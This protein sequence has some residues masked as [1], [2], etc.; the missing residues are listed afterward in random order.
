MR[1]GVSMRGRSIGMILLAC[2]LI[3]AGLVALLS[4]SFAGLGLLMGVL[5]LLAGAFLLLGR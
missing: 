1:G 4:L 2:Y 3:L 5:A